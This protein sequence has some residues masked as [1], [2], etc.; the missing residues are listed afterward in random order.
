MELNL[1]TINGND[2]IATTIETLTPVTLGVITSEAENTVV[3]IA[4][5]VKSFN[6]SNIDYVAL[7]SIGL[8]V[9]LIAAAGHNVYQ[10]EKY[11]SVKNIALGVTGLAATAYGVYKILA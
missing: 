9:G 1:N 6:D 4:G 10:G 5:N 7:G 8:G 11:T 3:T 2:V